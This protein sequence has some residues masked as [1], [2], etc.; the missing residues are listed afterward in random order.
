MR[1]IGRPA[2]GARSALIAQFQAL[3]RA[4]V[5]SGA[6]AMIG[7]RAHH[8]AAR[9]LAI[10]RQIVP[11]RSGR[12]GKL[13][14]D[15]RA[16]ELDRKPFAEGGDL[17]H[18]RGGGDVGG[19]DVGKPH[20]PGCRARLGRAERRAV[21]DGVSEDR[22]GVATRILEEHHARAPLGTRGAPQEPHPATERQPRVGERDERERAA[23]GERS[24]DDLRGGHGSG[25]ERLV[26]LHGRVG[27]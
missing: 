22:M 4:S 10:V 11:I 24:G 1:S 15:A 17:G 8:K 13:D 7:Q 6:S 3:D 27:V 23:H 25:D 26:V 21:V 16:A 5:A 19:D 20:R 12:A 14:Q 9:N 18:A 2:R